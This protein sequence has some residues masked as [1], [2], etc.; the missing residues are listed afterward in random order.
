M[1][2]TNDTVALVTGASRGIGVHIVRALAARG[3]KLVLAARSAPGLRAVATEAEAA[4]AEVL[5]VPTDLGEPD[6]L[7]ALV[8]A[9]H[10]RFGRVD[11]LVNNAGVE[12]SYFFAEAAL[13]RLEWTIRINVTA[14]IALARLVL[15]GMIERDRGHI[16]N[17]ASLAGMGPTAFGEAYG[18]SKHAMIGFTS[19]LR[20]SLQ[21][22]GSQVSASAVCPGFVS[23]VGMFADKQAEQPEIR[24]P[25]FL[26]TSRPQKVAAAVLRATES[27]LPT[28]IVNP[29]LIRITLAVALLFPR[30]GE[31]L[32]RVLD[33][34]KPGHQAAL[35]ERAANPPA[36]VSPEP[37]DR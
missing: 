13:E 34:H 31:W 33:V 4:G 26:G 15:P 24:P 29:G 11:L 7:A 5:V 32:G 14:P 37:T 36:L 18:A 8:D 16:L 1:K 25:V 22:Q 28:V 17:V 2:I 30:L 19:A 21:T 9:A 27:N 23:E 6:S 3:T 35:G 12:G 10:S 20:A